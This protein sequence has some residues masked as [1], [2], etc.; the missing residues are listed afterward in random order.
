MK[1]PHTPNALNRN[2]PTSTKAPSASTPKVDPTS[3]G[4]ETVTSGPVFP[5]RF[6]SPM[7]GQGLT[8]EGGRSLYGPI[9]STMNRKP[10]RYTFSLALETP[11]AKTSR[12]AIRMYTVHGRTKQLR[13]VC[14]VANLVV[15]PRHW[16]RG[17]TLT[18]TA[19]DE[20]RALLDAIRDKLNALAADLIQRPRLLTPNDVRV[21]LYPPTVN[22]WPRAEQLAKTKGNTYPVAVK[23]YRAYVGDAQPT[24]DNLQAWCAAMIA[25]GLTVNSVIG[26]RAAAV[27][28]LRSA[29]VD[30]KGGRPKVKGDRKAGIAL[31]T[32]EL[33][34]LLRVD[35]PAD[36]ARWRDA[37]LIA[38]CCALR[39]SDWHHFKRANVGKEV[40]NCKTGKLTPL[41]AH[42]LITQLID[43]NG[44]DL[45]VPNRK[46]PVHPDVFRRIAR[47]AADLCPSLNDLV[48]VKGR[49]IPRWQA[50]TSH[51]G[52]RTFVSQ[53]IDRDTP[54]QDLIR[55][56]G[57][58]SVQQ[59]LAYH[60]T[61]MNAEQ[62][63]AKDVDIASRVIPLGVSVGKLRRVR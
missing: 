44:G 56:T 32:A 38:C 58:A 63:A 2:K 5:S 51:C 29:G 31:T 47:A 9:S 6:R 48:D 1:R 22:V 40:R 49:T 57:H 27:S 21:W 19:T 12:V 39:V 14:S 54:Y 3:K 36:L 8:N 62:R 25:D 46:R 35:L 18:A 43:R 23:R 61:T 41:P 13:R 16:V 20:Q 17:G 24:N 33:D 60:A 53:G 28:V 59:L 7:K 50:V 45:R 30:L 37:L 34:A 11:R 15:C 42:P 55:Y 52:R 10:L 4:P 26:Y